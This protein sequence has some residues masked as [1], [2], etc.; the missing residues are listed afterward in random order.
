MKSPEERIRELINLTKALR[1]EGGCPWDRKQTFESLRHLTIEEVYEL[2]DSLLSGNSDEIK[3][4][5]GDILLHIIFYATIASENEFFN[6]YDVSESISNKL[7]N[8]HPH[9]CLLYTSDAA[10]E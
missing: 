7:I 10:D 9:V 8:R 5:L 3:N 6:L 1:A 2:S 4:E